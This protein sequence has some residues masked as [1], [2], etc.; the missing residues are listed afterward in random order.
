MKVYLILGVAALILVFSAFRYVDN[1]SQQEYQVDKLQKEV[2]TYQRVEEA[3]N[4]SR[5]T[6]PYGDPNVAL[7]ELRE[8]LGSP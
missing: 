4:D 6:N 7:D 2:D 3:V 1:A 5:Q 8:R